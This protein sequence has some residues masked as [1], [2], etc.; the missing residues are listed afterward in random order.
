MHNTTANIFAAEAPTTLI[1]TGESEDAGSVETIG[2]CRIIVLDMY[3][4][5]ANIFIAEAPTTLIKTGESEDAGSVETI[6][7]LVRQTE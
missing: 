3:N 7:T 1:K 6:V 5:A 4:T 2:F